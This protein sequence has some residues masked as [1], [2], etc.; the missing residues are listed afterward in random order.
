MFHKL[1]KK[2]KK[3]LIAL[4]LLIGLSSSTFK[5]EDGGYFAI[6]SEV[7]KVNNMSYLVVYN[8]YT[9]SSGGVSTGVSVVNVTKDE[10][11]V[12]KLK[13]EIEYYKMK[14]FK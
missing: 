5:V 11:E 13:L 6:K 7:M 10:L 9:R 12:Q 14:L 4:V 1:N 3:F 2:M 8:K